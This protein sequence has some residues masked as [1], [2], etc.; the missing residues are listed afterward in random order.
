[1]SPGGRILVDCHWKDVGPVDMGAEFVHGEKSIIAEMAKK[2][3]WHLDKVSNIVYI[4][5]GGC[6]CFRV[7]K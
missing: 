6:S 4:L 2:Q 1:M 5:Y 7:S 3:H